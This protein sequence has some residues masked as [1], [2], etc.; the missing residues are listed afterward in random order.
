MHHFQPR[1]P[2]LPNIAQLHPICIANFPQRRHVPRRHRQ[3]H[4]LLRLGEPD[5]PGFQPGIFERHL[6]QIHPRPDVLAH[7]AHRA[8]QPARAAIGDGMVEPGIPRPRHHLNHA[9]LRHRVA[10]LHRRPRHLAGLR[11]HCER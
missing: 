5:F 3:R 4:A 9:L 1:S 11:I 6:C 8:G 7:L 10:D 2:K